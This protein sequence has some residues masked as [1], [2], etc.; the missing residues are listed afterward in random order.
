MESVVDVLSDFTEPSACTSCPTL[1]A[2]LSCRRIDSDGRISVN[3]TCWL[4]R[5]SWANEATAINVIARR[6]IYSVK[7]K[8]FLL[9]G[10]FADTDFF[11]VDIF[12]IC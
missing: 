5:H 10:F 3:E 8:P 9:F 6:T 7:V 4:F 2:T 1:E 12:F 11:F